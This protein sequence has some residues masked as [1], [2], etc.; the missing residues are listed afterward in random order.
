MSVKEVLL[1]LRH[2]RMGL[3]Q[4]PDQLKFSYLAIAEG[5]RQAG[6]VS[7]N[8]LAGKNCSVCAI[9]LNTIYNIM[10]LFKGLPLQKEVALTDDSDD[11]GAPP[12]LPPPRSESLKMQ[13]ILQSIL[14]A[15]GAAAAAVADGAL[16]ADPTFNPADLSNFPDS[17]QE[18]VVQV[19]GNGGKTSTERNL[20]LIFSDVVICFVQI[21]LPAVAAAVTPLLTVTAPGD[22]LR[23]DCWAEPTLPSRLT[24]LPNAF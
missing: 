16:M 18:N 15:Q 20:V 24:L 17:L 2:Y 11:D 13:Q 12:P 3:I 19:N 4:T 7:D 8:I 10:L 5:A 22:R 23:L 6:H 14:S 9:I 21:S 1:D